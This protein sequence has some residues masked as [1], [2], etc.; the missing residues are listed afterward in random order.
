M[1]LSQEHKINEWTLEGCQNEDMSLLSELRVRAIMP[2]LKAVNRFEAIRVVQRFTNDYQSEQT[3]K[4]ILDNNLVGF[5]MMEEEDTYFYLPYF[6]IDPNYHSTQLSEL[7]LTSLKE[8][9]QVAKKG[10]QICALKG[11][12]TKQFCLEQGF[13]YSHEDTYDIYYEY[14]SEVIHNKRSVIA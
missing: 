6:Y 4:I 14:H 8:Q 9:A 12:Q 5:Y 2:S 10:I 13:V 1:H 3:Y 11:C 7:V